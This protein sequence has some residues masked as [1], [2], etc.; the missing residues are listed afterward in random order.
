MNSLCSLPNKVFSEIKSHSVRQKGRDSVSLQPRSPGSSN[1]VF[2]WLWGVWQHVW[3]HLVFSFVSMPASHWFSR[4]HPWFLC[5]HN[6][7]LSYPI[8]QL[9]PVPQWLPFPPFPIT[10]CFLPTWL[11]TSLA[12]QWCT[13]PLS[14]ILYLILHVFQ[15]F[16][17]CLLLELL[18]FWLLNKL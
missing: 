10:W 7:H 17:S 13:S 1:L 15:P 2:I 4:S 11:R 3:F 18:P 12:L 8:L 14:F 5:L 16:A 6:S 9:P